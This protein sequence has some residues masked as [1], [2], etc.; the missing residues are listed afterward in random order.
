MGS[1]GAMGGKS[2]G[3]IAASGD[4]KQIILQV[5][6]EMAKTHKFI[7][8]TDIYDVIQ[9]KLSSGDFETA[10]NALSEDGQIYST[11]DNDI[12]SITD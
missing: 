3:E 7:H 11:Y 5:M 10:L 4:H 2:M 9:Q 8:K 12:Y 6:K 1:S